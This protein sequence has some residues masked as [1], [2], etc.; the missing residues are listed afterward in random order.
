M[1]FRISFNDRCAKD[2]PGVVHRLPIAGRGGLELIDRGALAKRV[3]DVVYRSVLSAWIIDLI[4]N[5]SSVCVHFQ[6][7]NE[8]QGFGIP[9]PGFRHSFVD[10]YESFS[11]PL[12]E[13]WLQTAIAGCVQ[14]GAKQYRDDV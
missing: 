8:Q 2:F 4:R 7:G 11:I 10:V 5:P 1:K 12:I 14:R 3:T 9:G 6:A 13:S